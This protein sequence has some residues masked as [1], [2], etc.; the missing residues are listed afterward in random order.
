MLLRQSSPD[1]KVGRNDIV[2]KIRITIIENEGES[3]QVMFCENSLVLFTLESKKPFKLKGGKT[4]T[5]FL[6]IGKDILSVIIHE[7]INILSVY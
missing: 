5:C 3:S 2:L 4:F 1:Y 6:S 7:Q